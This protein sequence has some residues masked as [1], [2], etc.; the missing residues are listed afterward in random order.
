MKDQMIRLNIVLLSLLSFTLTACA[1]QNVI[2]GE[3]LSGESQSNTVDKASNG[4]EFFQGS[5]EDARALAAQEDKPVFVYFYGDWI[6]SSIGM[7][8][9]VFPKPEVGEYFNE[10]F[11][12]YQFNVG[13]PDPRNRASVLDFQFGDVIPKYLIM[14]SQGVVL[15]R[16]HGSAS[17]RQ[18]ISIISQAIGET[19]STFAA[20]QKRYEQGDRSTEFIQQFLMAAIEKL[21][22]R[23]LDHQDEA[24]VQAFEN[25][26]AKYKKIADKYF[27]HKPYADLINE[28]DAHLIMYFYERSGRGDELVAYVIDHYDEFLTV[29]SE[30]AMAKFTI[31]S[32]SLALRTAARTG[33]DRYVE[34]FETLESYPMKQAIAYEHSRGRMIQFWTDF[35]YA[36]DLDYFRAKG[37]W[38]ALHD[39]YLKRL[40]E[41]GDDIPARV[42]WNVTLQLLACEQPTVNKAAVEYARRAFEL[43][44]K[45]PDFTATYISALTAAEKKYSAVQVTENYRKRMT[46]TEHDKVTLKEFNKLLSTNLD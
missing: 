37:D 7:L 26:G 27:E 6:G 19:K 22:F 25:E 29:S 31:G 38:D 18:I 39:V 20:M 21:A 10:K 9:A 44:D 4:I 11:V 28:T 2:V 32:T 41:M 14:D 33:D 16:A 23:K 35:N 45:N 30:V 12:N 34:Y 8:E 24:S 5:F 42:F 17:P 43:D 1:N 13:N 46:R 36:W 15:G 3:E 40:E